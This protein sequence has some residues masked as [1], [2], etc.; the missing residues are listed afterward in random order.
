MRKRPCRITAE[1]IDR[2]ALRLRELERAPA[3]VRK[4]VC[5]LYTSGGSRGCAAP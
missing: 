3:T 5:L 2:Y 1:Q 4:Y